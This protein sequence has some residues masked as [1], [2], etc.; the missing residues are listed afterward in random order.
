MNTNKHVSG[1]SGQ[2]QLPRARFRAAIIVIVIIISPRLG[3]R[4]PLQQYQLFGGSLKVLVPKMLWASEDEN[5]HDPIRCRESP[6]ES[7]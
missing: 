1:Y 3:T 7:N 5:D 6:R 2:L 4:K